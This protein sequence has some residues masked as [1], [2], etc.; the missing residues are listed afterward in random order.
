MAVGA[1][2]AKQMNRHGGSLSTMQ[3][4]RLKINPLYL[5]L[6]FAPVAL[7]LSVGGF[8]QAVWVFI[9]SALAIIPLAGLMG[10]ATEHLAERTGPGI[11]GL[12]NATFGNAAEMIIALFALLEGLHSVVV[13][14]LAGSII[15]NSLLVLGLAILLGGLKRQ[16]Q[17]FNR[18]T[19]GLG[20]SLLLLSAVALVVPAVFHYIQVGA[21]SHQ[22]QQNEHNLSLSISIVL[23]VA[24]VLSL[25]FSLVT[26]RHLYGDRSQGQAESNLEAQTHSIWS[27][28]KALFLLIAATAGVAVMAELLVGAVEAAAQALSMTHLFVGVILVAIVGNAAE[29]STAVLMAMRNKMDL[30]YHIA[31]G[32]S[33]QIALFVAPVLVFISHCIGQ[34]LDL[35]FHPFEVVSV[36]LCALITTQVIA[37]GECHWMEGVLLL[38][39]YV[40]L[41]L[42]FFFLPEFSSAHH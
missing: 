6:L 3:L 21:L 13:A 8:E 4:G 31:V 2:G 37:D 26:H 39:V 40:I 16:R 12:L 38:T 24:Y 11:G 19:A 27:V 33:I 35:L 42:A 41:G 15:G 36:M 1:P 5:L 22:A 25:I 20:G 9:T 10:T 7:I 29:H 34:P 18:T 14:S 17:T 28:K 30:A 23:F 32:S